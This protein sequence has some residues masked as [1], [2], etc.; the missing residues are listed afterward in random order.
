[1]KS[2][3]LYVKKVNGVESTRCTSEER[4]RKRVG[5]IPEESN[6]QWVSWFDKDKQEHKIYADG[7]II[8]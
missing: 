8:K 4:A 3:R 7:K 5:F 1:M 6:I 2:F